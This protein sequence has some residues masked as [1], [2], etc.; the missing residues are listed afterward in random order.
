M[1]IR[2]LGGSIFVVYNVRVYYC[3][4]ASVADTENSSSVQMWQ[5]AILAYN[6]IA[7]HKSFAIRSFSIIKKGFEEMS[8]F[9]RISKN[10]STCD[11][12]FI[13][14]CPDKHH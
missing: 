4:I 1:Q 8:H 6:T 7:P 11:G 13:K 5:A 9:I 3:T 2:F 14:M 10:S 12:S